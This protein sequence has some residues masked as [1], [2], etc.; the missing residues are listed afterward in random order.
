MRRLAKVHNGFQCAI[1]NQ[2]AVL[3][4]HLD[5]SEAFDTVDPDILL[6]GLLMVWIS[7][8]VSIC[9]LLF[10]FSFRKRNNAS[11]Y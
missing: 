8:A 6:K 5:L 11:V 4:L 1:D 3:L 7:R 10:L 2:K 9:C